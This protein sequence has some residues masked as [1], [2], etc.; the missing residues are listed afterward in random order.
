MERNENM[1]IDQF[2]RHAGV[3]NFVSVRR[4]GLDNRFN[5]ILYG[6]IALILQ[7]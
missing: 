7:V 3:P 4:T 1:V 6:N 2:R 5:A